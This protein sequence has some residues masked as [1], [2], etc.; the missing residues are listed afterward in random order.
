M[1]HQVVILFPINRNA[2]IRT[3]CPIRSSVRV[4]YR[5]PKALFTV[6]QRERRER[7]TSTAALG[8]KHSASFD[9]SRHYPPSTCVLSYIHRFASLKTRLSPP[10]FF[11][12]LSILYNP[13]FCLQLRH[14][15]GLLGLSLFLLI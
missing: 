7:A 8:V 11:V 13:N 4:L 14:F 5:C 6:S 9:L 3:S 12:F 15:I 2:K 10:F 1:V